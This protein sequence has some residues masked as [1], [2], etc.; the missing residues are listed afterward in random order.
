VTKRVRQRNVQ[1]KIAKGFGQTSV[2]DGPGA[3]PS[4]AFS[5]L[6]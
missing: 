1:G 2:H 3:I 4:A 6:Y 5:L